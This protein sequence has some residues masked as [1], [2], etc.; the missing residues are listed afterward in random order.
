MV[1]GLFLDGVHCDAGDGNTYGDCSGTVAM[2]IVIV[3]VIDCNG[4]RE[5]CRR[6]GIGSWCCLVDM[7]MM[8]VMMVIVVVYGD[9]SDSG[10]VW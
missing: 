3:E 1:I 4:D 8:M 7:Q 10:C 2:V 5:W 6:V 9:G